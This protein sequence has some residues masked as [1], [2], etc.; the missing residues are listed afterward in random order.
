MASISYTI[1]FVSSEATAPAGVKVERR[2]LVDEVHDQLVE[3]LLEGHAPP[4][5]PLRI[6]HLA[7]TWGVSPTPVREALSRAAASGLV[8]RVPLRGFQVAPLLTEEQFA[9]LMDVRALL[10]PTGAALASAAGDDAVAVRL[11]EVHARMATA[12]RGPSA[13]DVQQYLRADVEFHQVLVHASGNAFLEA[14]L[15][16]T[17]AHAHRFRRFPGGVV[18]DADEALAEHAAVLAAVEAGDAEG[19]A[20]A[21]RSHLAGV[22]RRAVHAQG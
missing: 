20:D 4:G 8:E 5:S 22:R 16:T 14:A 1:P 17:A 15:A 19:A 21:M 6:D 10:E 18:T 13:H 2:T 12:P 7:R 3:L 9:Q 11:R